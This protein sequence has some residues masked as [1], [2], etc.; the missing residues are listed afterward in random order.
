EPQ[1]SYAQ[2]IEWLE[3]YVRCLDEDADNLWQTI[4]QERDVAVQ[5]AKQA[6]DALRREM[7]AAEQ[8][9]KAKLRWSLRRQAVGSACV[10]IGIVLSAW[11][12]LAASDP[13]SQGARQTDPSPAKTIGAVASPATAT[14]VERNVPSSGASYSK[15]TIPNW[16]SFPTN[17]DRS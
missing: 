2:R 9:R 14:A 4:Q 3:R 17:G 7:E 8:K 13:A 12:A 5:K 6:D 15:N 16:R 10:L 11:G 1:P